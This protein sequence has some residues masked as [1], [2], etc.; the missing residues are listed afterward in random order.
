MLYRI[1]VLEFI[2]IDSVRRS[3]FFSWISLYRFQNLLPTYITFFFFSNTTDYFE[4]LVDE[5]TGNDVYCCFI[6]IFHN[7]FIFLISFICFY[8]DFLFILLSFF[9]SSYFSF[10]FSLIFHHLFIFL[11]SFIHFHSDFHL[12]PTIFS[13]S[14]FPSFIFILSWFSWRREKGIKIYL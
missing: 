14:Y 1:A 6:F 11:F 8:C 2:G 10:L 9:S 7:L 5:I 13:F 3:T 4:N 12:F